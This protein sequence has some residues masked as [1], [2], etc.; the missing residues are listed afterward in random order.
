M[1]NGFLYAEDIS[2]IENLISEKTVAVMLELVKGEGGVEAQLKSEVQK[3]AKLLKSKNILLIIDE[4]QTGV[5]R[6]GEFLASQVYEI[7]P[8]IITL[9]KGLG[10]GVPI[11]V[12]ATTLKDGFSAGDHGSTF[13]GNFL[14]TS[15]AITVLEI[16]E[17]LKS[18]G[19][20]DLK[21]A[22][23]ESKIKFLMQKHSDVFM[24]IT[25]LGLMRG[26]IVK[27]DFD[28]LKIVQAGNNNG[29]LTLKSGNNTLRF[30]PPLLISNQEID[31]GFNRLDKSLEKLKNG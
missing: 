23:F 9:A 30:L 1:L 17:D 10:G 28:A 20:L 6:T 31:I 29:V 21:I 16:L 5:Y 8:D 26:L 13:G 3:L 11:G 27:S 25:G 12:M 19:N 18:S 4:V 14:S 7:Q 22:Y 15:S 2:N 24:N